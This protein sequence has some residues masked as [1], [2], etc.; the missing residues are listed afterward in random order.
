MS[1]FQNTKEIEN[2]TVGSNVMASGSVPTRFIQ[3]SEYLN[4]FNFDFNPL[5]VIGK[6]I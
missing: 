5:I 4:Y 6:G 3:F 2:P 1:S